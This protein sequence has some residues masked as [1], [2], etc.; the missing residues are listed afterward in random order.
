MTAE[1]IT[2]SLRDNRSSAL[3]WGAVLVVSVGLQLA[4]YPA[5][6]DARGDL[7]QL[8][9]AYPEAF[10]A[11]FG[12]QGSF[13]S[14]IGYVQAEVFGFLAP[15]VLLGVAIGQA[16]STTAAEERAGTLDL[17]LANPISRTRV[18]TDKALAILANLL[19]VTAAL[20]VTLVAGGRAV[21]LDVPIPDLLAACAAAVVVA[22]PFGALALLVGAGTGRSGFAVAVPVGVAMP[23]FL[24]DALSALSEDVRPWRVLSP[25]HHAGIDDALA[26]DPGWGGFAVLLLVTAVLLGSAAVTF[27]RH[28]IRR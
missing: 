16:A 26:G 7:D 15:L 25:F 14:G 1:L 6:R 24:L 12:V 28:D 22:L 20:A 21:G 17:L 5:V 3:G 23:A 19:A 11:L 13:T 9:D 18:L 4:V 10:K 27:Q 2:K 8:L